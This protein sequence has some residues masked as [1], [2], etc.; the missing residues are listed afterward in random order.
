MAEIRWTIHAQAPTTPRVTTEDFG[1]ATPY[2]GPRGEVG[3]KGEPGAKGSMGAIIMPTGFN[4]EDYR[5]PQGD[6]GSPGAKGEPGS[7]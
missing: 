6:K 1:A 5:G 7:E 2:T 3:I 4:L